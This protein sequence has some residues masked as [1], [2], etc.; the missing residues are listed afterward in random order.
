MRS[1]GM[2][3]VQVGIE[4]LSSKLLKKM[5]KGTTAIQNLEIMKNCEALGLQN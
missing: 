2:T 4:S 5:S 1:A 3:E